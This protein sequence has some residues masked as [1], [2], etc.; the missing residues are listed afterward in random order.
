MHRLVI[1]RYWENLDWVTKVPD[2]FE[3][4]IYNKG[5]PI[6]AKSIRV[7]GEIITRQNVGRES[8]TYLAHI[9]EA[10]CGGETS[11][12]VFAQGDPFEHSPDFLD[13]LRCVNDWRDI[14]PLS[15]RW[16]I[17]RDIP[18]AGILAR[19]TGEFVH[20]LR[21][22]PEIFSLSS[23]GPIGF[24]DP[25]TQWLNSTYRRLHRLPD[26]SNIAAHFLGLCGLDELAEEA[27]QH[28][29]G[30]CA[31][32]ALFGV[33]GANLASLPQHAIAAMMEASRAHGAYGYVM[34]RL[35]L[36]VFG[37]KFGLRLDLPQTQAQL[38]AVSEAPSRFLP[39]ESAGAVRRRKIAGFVGR[40][41]R[42]VSL[43]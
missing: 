37:E 7:R 41:K 4:L 9:A 15:W 11:F 8:E 22:R 31:Y 10:D 1:A 16:R 28:L 6:T 5:A 2:D 33:R 23:W 32:G 3:V 24:D 42:L 21:V 12:T 27:R 39:P 30:K 36:H 26:G 20:G 14:Q 34:E 38:R 29:L 19:E 18:P 35:W 25:G 40:L 17:A 43:R 13:L